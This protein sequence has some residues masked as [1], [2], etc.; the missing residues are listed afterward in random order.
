VLEDLVV[1]PAA[2]TAQQIPS[3]CGKVLGALGQFI[4]YTSRFPYGS[5][6][7]LNAPYVAQYAILTQREAMAQAAMRYAGGLVVALD[8]NENVSP[9]RLL[10]GRPQIGQ[11]AKVYDEQTARSGTAYAVVWR[12]GRAMGA[13]EVVR[14]PGDRKA[15]ATALAQTQW[16]R[17]VH[18]R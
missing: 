1:R 4:P 7:G 14:V 5:P 9:P 2:S 12:D 6:P 10:S 11:T 16:T 18:L 8:L 15:L 17:W 3:A 13:V